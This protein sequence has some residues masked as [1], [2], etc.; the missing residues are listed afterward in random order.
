LQF[1]VV[2][3]PATD[4]YDE[5]FIETSDYD[6]GFAKIVHSFQPV[7]QNFLQEES[8]GFHPTKETGIRLGWDDEQIL[9]WYIRAMAESAPASGKRLD[10]PL[11]VLG[12]KIDV[13]Q[14]GNTSWETLNMVTSKKDITLQ[15]LNF[16]KIR[17][18]IAIPGISIANKRRC[19]RKFLVTHV[20]CKLGR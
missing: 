14:Q 20:F 5:A 4:G 16:G 19:I 7:S 13:R 9:T 1:P 18:R 12:Y 6:D 3:N 15:K 2:N 17:G 10:C 8:D 11:G